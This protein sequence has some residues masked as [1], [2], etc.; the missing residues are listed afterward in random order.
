M[1]PYR[2][3]RLHRASAIWIYD[4]QS[5]LTDTSLATVLRLHYPEARL[6]EQ[7]GVFC[8]ECLSHK[9]YPARDRCLS[10]LGYHRVTKHPQS[11]KEEDA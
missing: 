5:A 6:T 11:V 3:V 1:G 2:L 8:A 4:I 9:F 10:W 7:W